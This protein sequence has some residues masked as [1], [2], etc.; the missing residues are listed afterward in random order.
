MEI[1][2]TKLSSPNTGHRKLWLVFLSC[3]GKPEDSVAQNSHFRRPNDPAAVPA[4]QAAQ[5]VQPIILLLTQAPLG[6]GGSLPLLVDGKSFHAAVHLRAAKDPSVQGKPTHRAF[7]SKG[8][9]LLLK[10][11]PWKRELGHV[12]WP[13][14]TVQV[15]CAQ[16]VPERKGKRPSFRNTE[17]LFY[18]STQHLSFE[19]TTEILASFVK[20]LWF[21]VLMILKSKRSYC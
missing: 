18:N 17:M 15:W 1:Q 9:N 11:S 13:S 5:A 7:L 14:N 19:N 12:L 2:Q 21:L 8:K 4:L 10:F 16:G 6:W 20:L 3:C